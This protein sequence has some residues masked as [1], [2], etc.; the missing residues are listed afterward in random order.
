MS[1]AAL[2]VTPDVI[3]ELYARAEPYWHTRSGEVHMPQAYAFAHALLRA[4]PHA[5]AGIV[6]PAI[7]LHDTGYAR[8]PEQTHHQ[9]LAQS[10]AGWNPDVTRLHEQEGVILARELLRAVHYPP[11]LVDPILRIIDGHDSQTAVAHS[12][13]DAIVKDADKLWRYGA[14]GV[15]ICRAWVNMTFLDF[16]AYVEG[17]VPTWFHT[18]EGARLA[19]V[20]L[21]RTRREGAS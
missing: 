14:Q 8:V 1:S 21:E 6:L 7:L 13:E 16:T 3:A 9:G 4:H 18:A 10:P 12:P 17:K 15:R 20:T 19:R 2:E 5:D 11:S